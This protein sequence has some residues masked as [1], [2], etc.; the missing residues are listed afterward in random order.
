MEQEFKIYVAPI[1]IDNHKTIGLIS[2]F[3]DDED[4]PLIICTPLFEE[5]NTDDLTK[6]LLSKTVSV[7]FLDENNTEYLGYETIIECN[8]N[9]QNRLNGAKFFP[10]KLSY[11]RSALDQMTMWFGMRSQKEDRSAITLSFIKSLV[12][13]DLFIQDFIPQNHLYH[14]SGVI[15]FI[16]L[17]RKEPGYYQEMDIVRLLHRL[18]LP[19]QIYLNPMRVT[20]NEEIADILIATNKNILLIQAKDSPNTESIIR[21]T[22]TRKKSAT[23]KKLNGAIKQTKGALRYIGSSSRI[24]IIIDEKEKE[25][26]IGDRKLRTLVLVKELFNDGF[27]IYGPIILSLVKS[28]NTPCIA[29]DYS[30]LNIYTSNLADEFSFFEAYDKVSD[31]GIQNGVFPRL[32][33]LPRHEE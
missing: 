28:T 16:E 7:Y 3:F 1:N 8:E 5:P 14:G 10:F 21:N 24:K 29:L 23:L 18:F 22:I 31:Y 32:R 19:E 2:A 20:D 33:I 17:E 11:T 6:L 15:R 25:I 9:T 27:S 30:E 12:P 13:E 4:E 26:E